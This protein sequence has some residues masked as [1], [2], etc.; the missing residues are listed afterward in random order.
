MKVQLSRPT[1][2][3]SNGSSNVVEFIRKS[4]FLF[5]VAAAAVFCRL[6]LLNCV[7]LKGGANKTNLTFTKY[8]N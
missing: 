6:Y 1:M 8:S 3:C 7:Q 2:P 4:H 5:A